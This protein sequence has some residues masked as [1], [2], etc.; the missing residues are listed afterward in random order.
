M[1]VIGH[2][3]AR[4]EAPENTL[5][6]LEYARR[7]GVVAFEVDIRLSA[8]GQAV[9]LHD[10]TVDRTTDGSGRAADLTVRELSELDA[11]ANFSDWPE[12]V[13]V[14]T[15]EEALSILHDA[16]L[17]HLEIKSDSPE[18]LEGLC[19][20]VIDLVRKHSLADRTAML[21][22]EPV[23][24]EIMRRIAPEQPR[25]LIGS[26]DSEDF[27]Q[28]ALQLGCAGACMG[29]QST[30]TDI[31]HLVR[32]S[33]L[34]VTV[35]TVNDLDELGALLDWDTVGVATDVPGKVIPFL[36]RRGCLTTE[37]KP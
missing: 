4:G 19:Q 13:G 1:I 7:L 23:V 2:R 30:T 6:G 37:L 35:W 12:K 20:Q 27:V 26:Y 18:R 17:L 36:R 14:P 21:S 25:A 3:G 32:S 33:G 28:R 10:E 29:F 34:W 22:F 8:D 16:K 31:V 24:L 15:L 11:R 9:L 5:A